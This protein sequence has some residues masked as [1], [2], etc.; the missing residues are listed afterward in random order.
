MHMSLRGSHRMKAVRYCTIFVW[1]PLAGSL[2]CAGCATVISQGALDKADQTLSFEQILENPQAHKG[3][4]VLL[5][6][7]I[8]ETQILSGRTLITVLQRPLGFNK[9]PRDDDV[10]KGR[11]IVYTLDFLDPAIYRRGR[12]ITVVG[13]VKGRELRLLSE[14]EYSYPV[15]EKKELYLWPTNSHFVT[16]PR[17]HFGVGIGIW[18]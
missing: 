17:V 2:L 4:I 14:I 10:S 1:I 11:F 6:G 13:T 18:R 15:I 7:D 3:R 9:K 16:E 12:K 5:G 8:I